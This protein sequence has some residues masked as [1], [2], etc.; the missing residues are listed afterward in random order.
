MTDA[1]RTDTTGSALPAGTVDAHHH[2]WRRADLPW[3]DGPV[4]P[5]IFGPYEPIQ[6]DYLIDEYR[7]DA[8]PV[9]VDRSVYIQ[10]NWPVER[11][12]DEVVWVQDVAD[13]SGWPHAI[14][15]SADMFAPDC[16]GVFARL[17][18]RAPLL[19]G[20]RVQLH[21]HEVEL[22]RFALAPDRMHDPVF[23]RNLALL[24]DYGWLFELQVF[25]QQMADAAR[26]VA[27][28]PDVTFVL[29]HAGMLESDDAGVVARWRAGLARL[30]EHQNVF[31][32][33]SGL[34]TFVR[35]V[36]VGVIAPIVGECLDVFGPH[37]CVWGSN[38]PVEKL[39]TQYAPLADAYARV[40]S[41][42]DDDT[43]TAVFRTTAERLYRLGTESTPT[44]KDQ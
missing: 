13:S 7:A 11:S 44:T 17:A 16:A 31:V 24:P 2:I 28:H 3:L 42:Y 21:W 41:S 29:V 6:R 35:A 1:P 8:E 10:T 27:E 26:L 20:M 14:V 18:D 30:A 33:L 43:R 12:F 23:R 40:F 38:F 15:G 39:W 5:R 34:G 9:G 19:R 36:D 22:Y 4:V 25:G 32:K 37:R